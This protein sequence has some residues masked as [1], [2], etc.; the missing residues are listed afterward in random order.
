MMVVASAG[1]EDV[2]TVYLAD[3]GD[4][5][6]IEF[7]QSVQPPIPR[8]EKWVIIIS[9]L[10]GCPV[11]CPICDAGGRFRGR[12]TR[13]EMLAQ[14]A[15]LVD[16]EFPDRRV[17]VEK[18]KIQFARMG[19]PAFNPAVIEVLDALPGIFDSPGLM[20]SISTVAPAGR[21]DF[22]AGL[23]AVK[24]SRYGKG[25]FQMQFSIHTTDPAARDRLIPV[26]KWDFPRIARFGEE[27]FEPGDRKIALNFALAQGSEVSSYVLLDHFDPRIFLIKATPVN[28]TLAASANGIVNALAAETG[29]AV[30]A[31]IDELRRAG[32]EVILS[33]G[34]L[35]ENKIGS[36]CG[37]LVRRYLDGEGSRADESYR[38]PVKAV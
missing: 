7:V 5:R 38:Y 35:E 37:Q 23:L 20:P 32:Y 29:A 15:F 26:D 14:I 31:S 28:P 16:R 11:A 8:E 10:V 33:I 25:R 13:E 21:E 22:F 6:L 3:L 30:P 17:P 24:R 9:T 18:F 12:L 36:N 1:R 34:E 19:E 4:S 27:F 2:A